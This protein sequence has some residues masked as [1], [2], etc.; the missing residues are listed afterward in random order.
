MTTQLQQAKAGTIT[1]QMRYVAQAEGVDPELLRAEVAAGRVVIPAN[2]VHL[3]TNLRPMGIGR[4]LTT[5]VNANIG[6]SSIR[7]SVQPGAFRIRPSP[8]G[9]GWF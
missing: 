8:P 9:S 3:K 4:I 6:T 5:K 1:E 7:A 2:T